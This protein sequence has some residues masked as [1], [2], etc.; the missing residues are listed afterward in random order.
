MKAMDENCDL[1]QDLY[2]DDENRCESCEG[3]GEIVV[4]WEYPDYVDC[5][6]CKGTGK[7]RDFLDEADEAYERKRDW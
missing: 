4:G 5:P 6:H 1:E 2:E 7:A 3:T